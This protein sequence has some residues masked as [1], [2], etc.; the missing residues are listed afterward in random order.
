MA[1]NG[2][3]RLDDSPAA[4]TAVLVRSPQNTGH[5]S[6]KWCPYGLVADQAADQR[7]DD[8]KSVTFDSAPLADRVEILGAP[9]VTLEVSADK[10]N[11]LVCVRLN[12]VAPDG[13]SL[14]VTYGL[15]NLTHRDSHER[16]EPLEP[17]RRYKVRVKL[18]DIA[19][20]F[21]PG[22][23]IRV[24]M[25]NAYWPIAW[26][27]PEPVALTLHTG[28]SQLELPVRAPR[29]EDAKLPDLPPAEGAPPEPMTTLRAG[30][31]SRRWTRD[32]TTGE[33]VFILESDDGVTR[34]DTHGLE[35]GGGRRAVYRIGEAD[36]NSASLDIAFRLEV[37][38]GDWRVRTETRTVMR[39]TPTEFLFE[40]TL[41]AWEGDVRVCS[42]NWSTRVPRDLV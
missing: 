23:R 19:H 6:G 22:H 42:R 13:S 34:F 12:D 18:N 35:T 11:A 16:P 26:P 33:T 1:L 3:G 39:S 17:G 37:G 27:S 25:S 2:A 21:A 5:G 41:D 32:I 28:G 36:P 7:E 30:G 10:P 4:E 20:A 40:A 31:D 8:G 24:A 9:V 38:R 15:L 29:P 14:R